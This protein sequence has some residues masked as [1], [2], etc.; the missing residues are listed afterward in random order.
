MNETPVRIAALHCYPIKSC[1]GVAL[2]TGRLEMLGFP[3]DRAWM[4]ARADTGRQVTQRDAPGMALI[5][6]QVDSDALRVSAPGMPEL[7]IPLRTDSPR[8]RREISVWS[9][10]GPADDEGEVAAAWFSDYLGF[11]ARL[12]RW[13]DDVRRACNPDWVGPF[14]AAVRFADAYPYLFISEASLAELNGRLQAAGRDPVP[15]NR[16]RPN[17]VL[18]GADA[19]AEDRVARWTAAAGVDLRPV[20]PCDRCIITCTD[21]ATA[22]VAK[23]PLRTLAGYRRDPRFTSPVFGQNVVLVGGAGQMLSVGQELHPEPLATN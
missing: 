4:V 8:A 1:A 16:F 10:D 6:P 23:E 11:S 14:P 17:V 13:R 19:F 21:Q 9:F 15:M 18:A 12:T 22:I 3:Y 2:P 20:K 7:V 5:Q